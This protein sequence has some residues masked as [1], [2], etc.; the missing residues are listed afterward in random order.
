[1]YLSTWEYAQDIPWK[2][3]ILVVKMIGY[4]HDD[5]AYPYASYWILQI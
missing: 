4:E 3:L 2:E 1:M 5:T